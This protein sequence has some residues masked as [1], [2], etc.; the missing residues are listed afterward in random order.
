[1]NPQICMP[2]WLPH[3]RRLI[4]PRLLFFDMNQFAES[5]CVDLQKV[6]GLATF[7]NIRCII[8]H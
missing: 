3:F 5:S 7:L 4:P 8:I 1:M 2:T 6:N